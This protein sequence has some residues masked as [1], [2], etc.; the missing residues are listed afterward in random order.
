MVLVQAS[1]KW[2]LL[3]LM[4]S[5]MPA[6]VTISHTQCIVNATVLVRIY[7]RCQIVITYVRNTLRIIH[8]MNDE[9]EMIWMKTVTA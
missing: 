5:K 2:Y 1:L 9:L 3:L 6:A 7:V 4:V 8:L